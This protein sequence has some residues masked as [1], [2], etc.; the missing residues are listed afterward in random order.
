MTL[1]APQK[2]LCDHFKGHSSTNLWFV[3]CW[4]IWTG[5]FITDYVYSLFCLFAYFLLL[6][7]PALRIHNFTVLPSHNSTF[8]YTNDSAYSNFSAT[9]GEDLLVFF[10]LHLSGLDGSCNIGFRVNS[11]FWFKG[12]VVKSVYCYYSQTLLGKH[13]CNVTWIAGMLGAASP[14][15]SHGRMGPKGSP[16]PKKISI[17][18]K[19]NRGDTSEEHM[20]I[21][22]LIFFL[23]FKAKMEKNPSVFHCFMIVF[24]GHI[25]KD[26][27]KQI[28][29]A[30]KWDLVSHDS[31]G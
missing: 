14:R 5:Q 27:C 30:W 23:S 19:R 24:R 2:C 22:R 3:L 4:E 31:L 17:R 28:C 25:K 1:P 11:E 6:F 26:K 12:H 10:V 7:H 21:N 18:L 13:S 16:K 9:V 20:R 29:K 15:E 8:V